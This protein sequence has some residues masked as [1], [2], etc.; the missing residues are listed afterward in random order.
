MTPYVTNTEANTYFESRLHS[1]AWDT[2]TS[3]NRTKATK[4]ATLIIDRLNFLGEKFS[5]DQERQFPRYDD[6]TVPDD[7]K[8]ATCE[9]ALAL[10]DGV[11]PD[12]EYENLFMQSQQYANVRSTY[13][14]TRSPENIVAGVP[15]VRAWRYL[16]PYL[17]DQQSV[18]LNRI[19]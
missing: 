1:E 12:M 13:D 19:S 7:I 9:I 11:D 5:E 8:N 17:R 6:S 4:E 2:A 14:R 10:L 16:R 15:S 3:T 18:H